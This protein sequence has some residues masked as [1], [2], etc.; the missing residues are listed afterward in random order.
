M[1]VAVSMRVN[2]KKRMKVRD[3]FL[4]APH[5][6]VQ[7]RVWFMIWTKSRSEMYAVRKKGTAR[8]PRIIRQI[9]AIID[10]LGLGR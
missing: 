7:A 1:S 9:Q 2:M 8:S 5:S 3:V 4:I 6:R 10:T